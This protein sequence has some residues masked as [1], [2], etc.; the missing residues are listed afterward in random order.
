[1]GRSPWILAISALIV[2]WTL[3]AVA[4]AYFCSSVVTRALSWAMCRARA[5]LAPAAVFQVASSVL[6]LAS[7]VASAFLSAAS[8][9]ALAVLLVPLVPLVLPVPVTEPIPIGM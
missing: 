6:S 4:F 3:A 5:L 8:L 7:S 2:A 9:T 1:M